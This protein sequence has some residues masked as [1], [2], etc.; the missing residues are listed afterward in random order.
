MPTNHPRRRILALAAAFLVTSLS[1]ALASTA[2]AATPTDD[3]M[4]MTSSSV[5][6]ANASPQAWT[7]D[8][9]ITYNSRGANGMWGAYSAGQ[10]GGNV[11]TWSAGPTN[12]GAGD[13]TPDGKYAILTQERT[14]HFGAAIGAQSTEPGKGAWNDL[15]L[16]DRRNNWQ[17]TGPGTPISSGNAVIWPRFNADGTKLIW[18]QQYHLLTGTELFGFW[19]MK[20]ADLVWA[21]GVPSLANVQIL[22]PQTGRFYESYGFSADG[23]RVIFASDMFHAGWNDTQIWSMNIDGTDWQQV[24]P[25]GMP[26]IGMLSYC[27]FAT[28]PLTD[29][30]IVFGRGWGWSKGGMDYWVRT[31]SG[32]LYQL[33]T[34][35]QTQPNKI[36]GGFAVSPDGRRMI[37]GYAF[38]TMGE[39]ISATM[40]NIS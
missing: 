25:T 30:S 14:S 18:S 34:L 40:I 9:R 27:E 32:G 8:N 31:P 33:T 21:D 28:A 20:T 7:L 4:T 26:V 22:E 36:P 29:G 15:V 23:T 19:Q 5:W 37:A 35:S 17:L 38:D 2:N 16:T 6:K 11:K 13:V 3:P 39:S 10:Y 12:R 1:T 24:S